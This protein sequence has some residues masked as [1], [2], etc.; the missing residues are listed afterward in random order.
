MCRLAV[1][2]SHPTSYMAEFYRCLARRGGID[3]TVLYCSAYG[4]EADPRPAI[5]FQRRI[6]WDVDPFEGYRSKMLGPSTRAHPRK[7]WSVLGLQILS[8]LRADRYDVVVV[9]GWAYPVCWLAVAAAGARRLPFLLYGDTNIRDARPGW[10]GALHRGVVGAFCRRAAGALYSGTFN[11]DFYIRLGLSPERLWFAPYAVESARF[12]AGDREEARTRLGLRE[13]T[14]YFL[15]VGA[16][17]NRKRPLSVV[18]AVHRL[19]L[20]GQPAGA[21]FVG[22]GELEDALRSRAAQ[23]GMDE[24][25]MVGFVNQTQLPQLYAAAD[26]LVLPSIKDPRATVV[27]EAM[28]AGKPVIV[29]TGTG[30]WGPGDLV[31]NGK[32]GFVVDTDDDAALVAACRALMDGTLRSQM[33]RA[34]SARAEYWSFDRAARGWEEAAASLTGRRH[35]VA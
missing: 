6:V 10:M 35:R 2:S 11:R 3:F 23:L 25:H 4:T 1:V 12:A 13:D 34:A 30:V 20:A 24:A 14:V 28:A 17:I 29:S 8:E 31:T 22:T 19:Q 27:N 7:R 21:L 32:E 9:Y 15:F 26:V 33:G 5:R 16:L 18:E